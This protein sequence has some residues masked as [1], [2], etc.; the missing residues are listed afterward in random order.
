MALA[1]P[2]PDYFVP[3]GEVADAP[4]GFIAMC[5]R[6]Q[7]LC[8]AGISPAGASSRAVA[9]QVTDCG[10]GA[11]SLHGFSTAPTKRSTELWS[12]NEDRLQPCA[13]SSPATFATSATSAAINSPAY[14]SAP[15]IGMPLDR[16]TGLGTAAT[17]AASRSLGRYST[18][19]IAMP[20]NIGDEAL[21]VRAINKQVNRQVVRV[22][23]SVSKGVDEEWDRPGKIGRPP[24]D[25]EDFAIEKRMRLIDA[26]FPPDRMFFAVVYKARF[27]LHTVLVTRLNDG[28]YVLDSATPDV[29]RWSKT[30]YVWLRA[31]SPQDPMRWTRIGT[32]A[33]ASSQS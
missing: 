17:G 33:S 19:E 10:P 25:C 18:R 6:D 21:M 15:V 20:A 31:Q 7:L 14:A 23:D 11:A 30:P 3:N 26:G 24:G 16:S 8:R 32:P 28:D 27:G 12:E 13:L 22:S 1:A 5:L 29:V 4:A 2:A 9:M